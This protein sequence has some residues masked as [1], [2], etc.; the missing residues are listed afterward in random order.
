MHARRRAAPEQPAH[1]CCFYGFGPVQKRNVAIR[2]LRYALGPTVI[3]GSNVAPERWEAMVMLEKSLFAREDNTE[4]EALMSKFCMSVGVVDLEK[5]LGATMIA[6][7]ERVES[8]DR[9][10]GNMHVKRNRQLRQT[11]EGFVRRRREVEHTLRVEQEMGVG[12]TLANMLHL[13]RELRGW[14]SNRDA[15]NQELTLA[16]RSLGDALVCL[17]LVISMVEH[18]SFNADWTDAVET[19]RIV[20][21]RFARL[22]RAAPPPPRRPPPRPPMCARVRAKERVCIAFHMFCL[23]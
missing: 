2:A 21:L 17:N 9:C 18:R 7:Y 1:W 4:L 19:G 6:C 23:D 16:Q 3:H 13:H 14:H 5:Y 12:F 11:L 8:G 10:F 15:A 20:T 22:P